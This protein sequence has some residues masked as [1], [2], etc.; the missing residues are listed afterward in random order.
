VSFHHDKFP[1]PA[2]L[3]AYIERLQGT[4]KLRPDMKLVISRAWGDPQAR[5]N[6]LF[7]LTKGLGA[8]VRKAEQRERA[9]A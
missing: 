5:L 4:A 8:V 3:M 2:G 6:G 9:A 1:D 7:Q